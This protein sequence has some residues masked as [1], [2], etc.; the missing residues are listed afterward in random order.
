[1]W[2]GYW[3][4]TAL[5][6]T[7][8]LAPIY[9]SLSPDRSIVP[10]SFR[11]G[12]GASWLVLPNQRF[13]VKDL[14]ILARRGTMGAVSPLRHPAESRT[15]WLTSSWSRTGVAEMRNLPQNDSSVSRQLASLGETG[16]AAQGNHSDVRLTSS[17]RRTGVAAAET[18]ELNANSSNFSHFSKF[19][20]SGN[21]GVTPVVHFEFNANHLLNANLRESAFQLRAVVAYV[22]SFLHGLTVGSATFP[23]FPIFWL[24]FVRSTKV[25]QF[26]IV[27]ISSPFFPFLL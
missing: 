25:Y 27:V 17:W 21:R 23:F 12:S 9:L 18:P 14:G 2:V 3:K 11:L 5:L 20:G 22:F 8:T 24:S 6:F 15:S 4:R 10:C 19:F 16:A 7:L 26:D 1:M 13:T